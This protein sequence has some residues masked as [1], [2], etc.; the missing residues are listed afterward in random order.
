MLDVVPAGAF[1][2]LHTTLISGV[3]SPLVIVPGPVL[4]PQLVLR[5]N[6][7]E[8]VPDPERATVMFV[9]LIGLIGSIGAV[10]LK[11]SVALSEIPAVGL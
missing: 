10:V 5:A 4:V 11:V 7:G 2:G 8:G 9:G 6:V 1:G 3:A